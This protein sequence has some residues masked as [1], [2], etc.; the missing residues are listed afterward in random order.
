MVALV[1][2][3]PYRVQISD[4]ALRVLAAVL[5][6]VALAALSV[7][8]VWASVWG[9][10]VSPG[11]Q[12]APV[13]VLPVVALLWAVYLTV[14]T[15]RGGT[16]GLRAVGLRVVRA[17]TQDR[18]RFGRSTV[19][20]LAVIAVVWALLAVRRWL[21]PIYGALMVLTAA[22]RL[23]HDFLAGSAVVRTFARGGTAGAA[24]A[25]PQGLSDVDPAQARHLLDDMGHV[26]RAARA[27]LHV[28]SV[29]VL[30]LGVLALG[31][32]GVAL[33]S[34]SYSLW[35]ALY[36]AVAAPA[37]LI[38]VLVLSQLVQRRAGIRRSQGW[39]VAATLMLLAAAVVGSFFFLGPAI[40]GLAF[41][42]VAAHE[43]SRVLAVF[44]FVVGIQELTGWFAYSLVSNRIPGT[45]LGD[46]MSQHG[47]AVVEGL[48]GAVLLVVGLLAYRSERAAR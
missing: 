30:T 9:Q 10:P 8:I 47:T 21:V 48:V 36:W 32:A 13:W 44:A 3:E 2:Q 14:T 41:L 39:L 26:R 12:P 46:L 19:R 15:W 25:R 37:G 35:S 1:E 6:G 11:P 38:L 34:R 22:R 29:A 27:D 45:A 23:P 42:G 17:G 24:L 33:V 43:G 18:L 28:P 20:S 40:V 16:P 31:G 5:D 7:L 4:V